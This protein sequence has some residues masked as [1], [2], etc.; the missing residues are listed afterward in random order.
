M[1]LQMVGEARGLPLRCA[2]KTV[3]RWFLGN[4]ARAD[5]QAELGRLRTVGPGRGP[6]PLPVAACKLPYPQGL[7]AGWSRRRFFS[8]SSLWK[9]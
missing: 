8:G 5:G 9:T 6:S 4:L 1:M 2:Q 3:R 7:A